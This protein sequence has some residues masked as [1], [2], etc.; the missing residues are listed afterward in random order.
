M[1]KTF[2]KI[3]AFAL[4]LLFGT[5]QSASAQTIDGSGKDDVGVVTSTIVTKTFETADDDATIEVTKGKVE[6]KYFSLA[7]GKGSKW[8]QMKT[9]ELATDG[10]NATGSEKPKKLTLSAK[11]SQKMRVEVTIGPDESATI[12]A[13]KM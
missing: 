8:K 2:L 3:G 4:F 1:K 6:Y 11:G 12:R 5:T 13:G 7:A 9:G 10:A